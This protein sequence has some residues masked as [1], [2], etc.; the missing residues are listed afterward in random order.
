MTICGDLGRSCIQS[1]K[2]G[3]GFVSSCQDVGQLKVCP[4]HLKTKR[5]QVGQ[6]PSI[7][8][9][10]LS[11]VYA[12]SDARHKKEILAKACHRKQTPQERR[13]VESR[14]CRH[15]QNRSASR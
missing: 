2:D 1:L 7:V 13:I 11:S 5:R 8:Y 6:T 14:L 10:I 3:L 15:P 4:R 9:H 12:C